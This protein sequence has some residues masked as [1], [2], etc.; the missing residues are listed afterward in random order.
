MKSCI[1][2]DFDRAKRKN[3]L[4]IILLHK[5]VSVVLLVPTV[6]VKIENLKKINNE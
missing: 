2:T 6:P 4:E 3:I 5:F 1:F